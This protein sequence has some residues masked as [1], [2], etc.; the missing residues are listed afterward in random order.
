MSKSKIMIFTGHFGSG[1]TEIALNIAMSNSPY[2]HQVLVDLDVVNPFYRSSEL[3]TE[4]EEKGVRLIS[5]NFAHTNMDL[6]SLPAEIQGCFSLEDTQIIFDMGGDDDGAKVLGVYNQYFLNRDYELY[7]VYNTRRPNTDTLD[8][9]LK[10]IQVIEKRSRLTVTHLISNSNLSSLTDV[11][12]I[13]EGIHRGV[14]L[15][16]TTNLPLAYVGVEEA[17]LAE[18]IDILM[19]ETYDI[20]MV[21][22][23]LKLYMTKWHGR[24]E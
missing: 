14:N 9:L 22:K 13:K 11:E 6:P 15:S 18:T 8:K 3:K 24:H 19:A 21:Y 4:L 7:F 2:N 5:P 12:T 23:P 20:D 10:M 17:L 1:K 16:E